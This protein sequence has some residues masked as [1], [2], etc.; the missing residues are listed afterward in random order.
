MAALEQDAS[1][2]QETAGNQQ[3]ATAAL[4]QYGCEKQLAAEQEDTQ[5]NDVSLAVLTEAQRERYAQTKVTGHLRLKGEGTEQ[6]FTKPRQNH[7]W[8]GIPSVTIAAVVNANKLL[9]WEVIEG[10]WNGEKAK[11]LY[12]GP[13]KK[14][15]E[16]E[17]GEKRTAACGGGGGSGSGAA[18]TAACSAPGCWRG[19]TGGSGIA[20]AAT[21]ACWT[22]SN[23]S[24]VHRGK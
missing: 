15:F 20:A 22:S 5:Q 17:Y 10:N 13:I 9:V 23:F 4:H 6:G 24:F 11:Q 8:L 1:E 14:A 2:N 18:A 3:E 21:A 19:G 16:R 12:T 7:Q